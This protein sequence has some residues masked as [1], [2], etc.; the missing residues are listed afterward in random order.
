MRVLLLLLSYKVSGINK[1]CLG[2]LQSAL[3]RPIQ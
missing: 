2:M 3:A 1:N